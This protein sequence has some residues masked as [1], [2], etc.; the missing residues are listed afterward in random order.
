MKELTKNFVDVYSPDL[1]ND[2][3]GGGGHYCGMLVRRCDEL[4]FQ[5]LRNDDRACI[6]RVCAS[7]LL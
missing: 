1:D 6:G 5:G 2:C 3:R 7:R 4:N